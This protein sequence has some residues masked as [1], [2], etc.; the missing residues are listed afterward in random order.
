[1]LLE[2]DA[3]ITELVA[4]LDATATSGGRVVL[5]RGEAGIGKTTLINRFAD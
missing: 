4:L 3:Q 5:V 2:R 1:M